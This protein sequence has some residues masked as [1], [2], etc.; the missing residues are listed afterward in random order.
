MYYVLFHKNGLSCYL[1]SPV[2]F[3]KAKP[4]SAIFL[5]VTV[6]NKASMMRFAN[7]RF[8]NSF[9]SITYKKNI[10]SVNFQFFP[11]W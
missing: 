9:I 8:W 10:K 7:L 5:P 6:L 2:S 1:V 11:S 3:L 4:N